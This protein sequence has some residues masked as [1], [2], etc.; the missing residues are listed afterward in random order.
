MLHNFGDS[1]SNKRDNK[2]VHQE[3]ISCQEQ[4]HHHLKTRLVM[5]FN[6]SKILIALTCRSLK[7]I[8]IARPPRIKSK[9]YEMKNKYRN[10]LHLNDLS[11]RIA[12]N[13]SLNEGDFSRN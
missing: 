7:V 11:K 10:V 3:G 1:F 5:G 6:F 13:C 4:A 8:P 12:S 2:R 9:G